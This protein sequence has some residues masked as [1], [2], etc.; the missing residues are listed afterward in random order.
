MTRPRTASS[1][2][3]VM[4]RLFVSLALALMLTACGSVD[5]I[6]ELWEDDPSDIGDDAPAYNVDGR[7][8]PSSPSGCFWNDG[9]RFTAPPTEAILSQSRNDLRMTVTRSGHVHQG[10]IAGTR[11][12][13]SSSRTT[14]GVTCDYEFYGEVMSNDELEGKEHAECNTGQGMT[15]EV[16]RLRRVE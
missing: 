8:S 3:Y 14:S 1:L 6:K 12:Y 10:R 2:E 5:D 4:K 13:V 11:F 15:C 16:T 9:S 7:F